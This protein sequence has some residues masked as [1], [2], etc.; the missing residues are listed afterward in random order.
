MEHGSLVH[1]AWSR[2]PGATP[3]VA[4]AFC[5][6]ETVI[7][8]TTYSMRRIVFCPRAFRTVPDLKS[9]MGNIGKGSRLDTFYSG[10]RMFVHEL[11]HLYPNST[12]L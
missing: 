3:D 1:G 7:A 5:G 12:L 9:Q 8:F 4:D 11:V 6:K 10:S 2:T